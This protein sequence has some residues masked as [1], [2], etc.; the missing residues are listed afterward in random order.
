MRASGSQTNPPPEVLAVI[1]A[2]AQVVHTRTRQT[3]SQEAG[4]VDDDRRH[5]TRWKFSGR[6]WAKGPVLRR[7][8]P[9][10]H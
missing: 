6:W 7:E 3:R 5:D 2:A 4:S 1:T 8:R 10:R 9:Q